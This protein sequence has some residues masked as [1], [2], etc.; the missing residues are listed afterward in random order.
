MGNSGRGKAKGV[1]MK[2]NSVTCKN[3]GK[4]FGKTELGKCR[5][6]QYGYKPGKCPFQKPEMEVT[7]GKRHPF[8]SQGVIDYEGKD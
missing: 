8:V 4:C 6:L 5:I 3:T 1:E 2:R 7:E